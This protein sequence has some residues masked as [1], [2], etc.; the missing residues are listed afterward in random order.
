VTTPA[1]SHA[2]LELLKHVESARDYYTAG[3]VSTS[4]RHARLYL[5]RQFVAWCCEAGL[6]PWP[7]DEH[8]VVRY[9][10]AC[11]LTGQAPG[12]IRNHK[13]A[14][15]WVHEEAGMP[16]PCEGQVL[17]LLV[18]IQRVSGHTP[19]QAEGLRP[20]DVAAMFSRDHR[21]LTLA[22][23]HALLGLSRS[24]RGTVG[25]VAELRIV[26]ADID[27]DRPTVTVALPGGE[28]RELHAD[29]DHR[30][31]R[32]S[33]AQ[34]VAFLRHLGDAGTTR[35]PLLTGSSGYAV[36]PTTVVATAR[37]HLERTGT[38]MAAGDVWGADLADTEA[39]TALRQ[40]DT[41]RLRALR[42]DAL[43]CLVYFGAMRL[44]E[45]RN[46]TVSDWQ[47]ERTSAGV[48][49]LIPESKTD[50]TGN[51]EV[52]VL[53]WATDGNRFSPAR[54][55]DAWILEAGLTT[56]DPI[57]PTMQ[58]G[59]VGEPPTRYTNTAGIRRQLQRMGLQARV[60]AH[61]TGHS[62]R[63]GW[64]TA[65]ASEGVALEEVMRH[66]RHQL[67]DTLRRYIDRDVAGDVT[68]PTVVQQA[69][70]AAA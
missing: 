4:T 37:R 11:H 56:S 43:L 64:A 6:R 65:A 55:V 38:T 52:V 5:W 47:H 29:G 59:T 57:I 36:T 15:K 19:K 20:D 40:L 9:L 31:L 21:R 3:G 25:E 68:V 62:G 50:Q 39:A 14:I 60:D 48:G 13:V 34:L 69:V 18:G 63:R 1:P 17:H 54:I 26:T 12:T 53:P 51:G 46:G 70:L 2:T 22:R 35:R 16:A 27:S 23:T 10:T 49:L 8:T 44:D 61:I 7:A 30:D 58:F 28:R 33:G 24:L 67:I 45:I 66:T 32:D 42:N 41:E